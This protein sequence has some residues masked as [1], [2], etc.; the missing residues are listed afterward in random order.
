M[1]AFFNVP[2]AIYGY[3]IRD[4]EI[5]HRPFIILASVAFIFYLFLILFCRYR[6]NFI[7]YTLPSTCRRICINTFGWHIYVIDI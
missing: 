6:L 3:I 1:R 5:S 2:G 7:L 4:K